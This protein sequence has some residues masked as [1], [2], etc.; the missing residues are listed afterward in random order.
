M[1]QAIMVHFS[2]SITRNLFLKKH[3]LVKIGNGI[4]FHRNH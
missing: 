2:I 3:I 4:S 1:Q